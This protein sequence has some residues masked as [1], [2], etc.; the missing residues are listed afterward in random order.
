MIPPSMMSRFHF[1]SV[2][3]LDFG[4]A[5]D[6]DRNSEMFDR[7]GSELQPASA[8]FHRP[9]EISMYC[10]RQSNLAITHK[11]RVQNGLMIRY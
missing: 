6:S 11:Y 4:G 7:K 9:V 3:R 8:T 2:F 10:I 5:D 1:D